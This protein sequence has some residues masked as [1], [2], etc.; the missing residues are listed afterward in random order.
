MEWK[1]IYCIVKNINEHNSIHIINILWILRK[2]RN[3]FIRNEVRLID[4]LNQNSKQILSRN[5]NHV[6]ISH[7][8]CL[9]RK[10]AAR[11]EQYATVY[12]PRKEF[13]K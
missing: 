8:E 1:K 9:S 6:S 12:K 3:N 7:I 13:E 4:E 11:P 2:N 10:L 5:K